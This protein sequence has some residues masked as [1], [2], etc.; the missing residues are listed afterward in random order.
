M[1]TSHRRLAM[2]RGIEWRDIVRET[3]EDRKQAIE[4]AL[5]A[6]K[7]INETHQLEA[8]DVVSWRDLAPLPLNDRL[9]VFLGE[10]GEPAEETKP[11]NDKPKSAKPAK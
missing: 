11:T 2:E 9:S 10:A 3:V 8:G 5:E 4:A 6:A 7:S 1:Q